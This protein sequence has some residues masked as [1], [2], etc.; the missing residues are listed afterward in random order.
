MRSTEKIF[1]IFIIVEK[2]FGPG[3][4]TMIKQMLERRKISLPHYSEHEIFVTEIRVAPVS[5]TLINNVI[6]EKCFKVF[7]TSDHVNIIIFQYPFI[8]IEIVV[9]PW[10]RDNGR[11]QIEPGFLACSSSNRDI[12]RRLQ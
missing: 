3:C 6:P 8:S 10:N 5:V 7:H 11:S 9:V 2:N 1:G 12:C 4:E